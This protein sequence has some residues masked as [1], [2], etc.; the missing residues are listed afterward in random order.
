MKQIYNLL[1]EWKSDNKYHRTIESFEFFQE[2]LEAYVESIKDDQ[3]SGIFRAI[4]LKVGI[5]EIVVYSKHNED[6]MLLSYG[7]HT[8]DNDM[9]INFAIQESELY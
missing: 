2:A 8:K 6:G 4:E 9:F 7:A 3:E 5:T 1:T